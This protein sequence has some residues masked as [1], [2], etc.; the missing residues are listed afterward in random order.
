[1]AMILIDKIFMLLTITLPVLFV[2]SS[3][4]S[5]ED[6]IVLP[7]LYT[8]DEGSSIFNLLGKRFLQYLNGALNLGLCSRILCCGKTLKSQREDTFSVPFC[9]L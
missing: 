4:V 9:L 7:R 5:M 3:I 1:M 6:I 2:I 8:T